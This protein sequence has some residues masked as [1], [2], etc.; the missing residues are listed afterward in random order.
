MTVTVV[1]D[2]SDERADDGSGNN[3]SVTGNLSESLLRTNLNTKVK[4][5]VHYQFQTT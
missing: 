4:Q 1:T 5:N 3:T 2:S